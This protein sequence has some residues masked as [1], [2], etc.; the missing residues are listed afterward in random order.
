MESAY[1]TKNQNEDLVQNGVISF[2]LSPLKKWIEMLK[3]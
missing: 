3:I 2:N 1:K